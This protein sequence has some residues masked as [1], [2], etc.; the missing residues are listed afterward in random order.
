MVKRSH[1]KLAIPEDTGDIRNEWSKLAVEKKELNLEIVLKC[2][3]SFR[4]TRS[5][6]EWI[7]VLKGHLYILKQTDSS[8]LF[9]VLPGNN[10]IEGL[11]R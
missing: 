5:D 9:K 6:D 8:L 2:G 3:Q 4:W 7:G 11:E 10:H 1:K